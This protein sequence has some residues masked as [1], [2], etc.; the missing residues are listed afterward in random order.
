M[1]RNIFYVITQ[2]TT[3]NKEVFEDNA[4]EY[5]T[6]VNEIAIPGTSKTYKQKVYHPFNK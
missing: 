1:S 2:F 4:D 5:F 3:V 6:E